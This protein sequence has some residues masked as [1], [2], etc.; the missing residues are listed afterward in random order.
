MN[1][2]Q[3]ACENEQKAWSG[4]KNRLNLHHGSFPRR[5]LHEQARAAVS[6]PETHLPFASAL[7]L[8]PDP[9]PS[10]GVSPVPPF[11]ACYN[12]APKCTTSLDDTCHEAAPHM[13]RI[14]LFLAQRCAPLYP[15]WSSE[16]SSL[17]AGAPDTRNSTHYTPR[18]RS[19]KQDRHA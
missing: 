13:P 3:F 1:K 19:S 17:S 10:E 4:E 15:L 16:R 12:P 18:T 8:Y 11:W 14:C 2:S 7:T 9:P 5:C 6:L